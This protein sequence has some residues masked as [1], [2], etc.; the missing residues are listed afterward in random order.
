[1]TPSQQAGWGESGSKLP[2][3][4]ASH[5]GPLRCSQWE[6]TFSRTIASLEKNELTRRFLA[7]I[8]LSDNND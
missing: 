3:Y 4:K 8:F 7:G 2:H 1:M 6:G 5:P